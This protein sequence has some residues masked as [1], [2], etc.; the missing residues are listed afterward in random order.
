VNEN[1]PPGSNQQQEELVEYSFCGMK[2]TEAFVVAEEGV[3]TGSRRGGAGAGAGSGRGGGGFATQPTSGDIDCFGDFG[4]NIR[5][6]PRQLP[7][8]GL[9]VSC[10]VAI[11][12]GSVQLSMLVDGSDHDR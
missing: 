5:I 8:V 3:G 10:I 2:W 11:A 4:G 6:T 7:A 1:S 9:V 12:V